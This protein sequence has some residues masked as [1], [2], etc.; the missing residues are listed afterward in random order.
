MSTIISIDDVK[1]HAKLATSKSDL[2][3]RLG[4]TKQYLVFFLK[5]RNITIE[6]SLNFSI[7][8]NSQA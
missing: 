5:S 4:V 1:K 8:K 6:T 3:R 2:A 7:K